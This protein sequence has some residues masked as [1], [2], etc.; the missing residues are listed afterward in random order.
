[1]DGDGQVTG[2]QVGGRAKEQA[3]R[4]PATVKT[5]KG[6]ERRA[7]DKCS[8]S[9]TKCIGDGESPCRRCT[10]Y[11]FA[12]EYKR[13]LKK[14]GKPAR[15]NQTAESD[16][17]EV[18]QRS[19]DSWPQYQKDNDNPI[20]DSQSTDRFAWNATTS[21]SRY[22]DATSQ[23]RFD[24]QAPPNDPYV[25]HLDRHLPSLYMETGMISPNSTVNHFEGQA[26]VGQTPLHQDESDL[27]GRCSVSLN[28]SSDKGPIPNCH[29]NHSPRGEYVETNFQRQHPCRPS[30]L[31]Q[32][33]LPPISL[34][35]SPNTAPR[36]FLDV[37]GPS[38]TGTYARCH[39][40]ATIQQPTP[41]SEC[42]YPILRPLL[43]HIKSIMSPTDACDL[44]DLYFTDPSCS[45]FEPASPYI[46]AQVFRKKSFLCSR[47]PRPTTPAL[48][49][50]MI[51]VVC[52]TSTSEIFRSKPRARLN[53]CSE[54]FGVCEALLASEENGNS[55]KVSEHHNNKLG[56]M[57]LR[58]EPERTFAC[59]I[60]PQQNP[61]SS[62]SVLAYALIGTVI[63]GSETRKE[64]LRWWTKA[65]NVA[66]E[67][68]LNREQGEDEARECARQACHQR[69]NDV[70][71]DSHYESIYIEESREERRRI[72]WLLFMADRHLS[73]C[74]NAPL[75]ILDAEC[76]VYQPLDDLTW[77]ALDTKST[78]DLP[79]RCLGP[80]TTMLGS[81][82]FEYFLP[83]MAILGDIVEIH[84]WGRHPRFGRLQREAAILRTEHDLDLYE[85][86]L[87]NFEEIVRIRFHE[88]EAP[89]A[90]STPDNTNSYCKPQPV[91]PEHARLRT[92]IGY[93]NYFLHVLHV[94]LHGSWDP[95]DMIDG[96]DWIT[97]NSF[98]KCATHTISAAATVAEILDYD[99]EL[100]FMPYL[101]GI[102]LLHGSFILLIFADRMDMA[103]S[104][105]IIR[106]CETTYRAHEVCVV[107]L[108]TEY[109]K[110]FKKVLRSA[111]C[112]VRGTIPFEAEQH[113]ARRREFLMMYR[114][115]GDGRGLAI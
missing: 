37:G 6:R 84:H 115:N 30:L 99:P 7:C 103:T 65:W 79:D 8:A 108:N 19:P 78:C 85:Q 13:V 50:T 101:F 40:L 9:R 93:S 95:V 109:Q 25:D 110:T 114:W 105:T 72:W 62:D 92:I 42:R 12:C 44:L 86:S 23:S 2:E 113:K 11:R 17:Q 96:S 14:R 57:G 70:E 76:H 3:D 20:F 26:E 87:R 107:T 18:V 60:V 77:Q 112:N 64:C 98:V 67:L 47:N 15:I 56:N 111:L 38:N 4:T 35:L 49:A 89:A 74:F 106:A 41:P 32:N 22:Q 48:L 104:E 80:C 36:V 75:S 5:R 69:T 68:G 16:G 100:N 45:I 88:A 1:M 52:Q 10:E 28:S 29:L 59:P 53:I 58:P 21:Q 73:F 27:T 54:L 83:L 94:L 24:F 61:I 82:V 55:R 66:K 97:P 81:D 39:D 33:Q 102:Y 43:P 90:F 71:Y 63:S 31:K 34:V 51:W 91:L 46:I